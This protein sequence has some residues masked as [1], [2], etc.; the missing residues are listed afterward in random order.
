[1]NE[2]ENMKGFSEDVKQR[3]LGLVWDRMTDRLKYNIKLNFTAKKSFLCWSE[4]KQ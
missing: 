3:V 1:M 2:E 4:H